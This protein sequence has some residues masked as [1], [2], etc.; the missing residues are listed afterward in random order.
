MKIKKNLSKSIFLLCTIVLFA[1]TTGLSN[2]AYGAESLQATTT[3]TKLIDASS[4]PLEVIA[5]TSVNNLQI[6][7]NDS[8]RKIKID[9]DLQDTFKNQNGISYSLILSDVSGKSKTFIYNDEVYLAVN[10]PVHKTLEES[11]PDYFSGKISV[12]IRVQN[13]SGLTLAVGYLLRSTDVSSVDK[14]LSIINN[15]CYLTVSSTS[16][17]EAN[18]KYNLVQ[19]VDLGLGEGLFLNCKVENKYSKSF[20]LIPEFNTYER[21]ISGNLI[22]NQKL[23]AISI[24]AGSSSV[25]IKVPLIIKSQSYDSVFSLQTVLN[26]DPSSNNVIFHYVIRGDSGTVNIVNTDKTSYLIEETAKIDLIWSPRADYFPNS[27][28]NWQ[29][30]ATSTGL[31]LLGTLSIIDANGEMCADPVNFYPSVEKTET[32]NLQAVI[33]KDCNNGFTTKID[34]EQT[35]EKTGQISKL[36][37]S[38]FD[39][40][41]IDKTVSAENPNSSQN[42]LII[43]NIIFILIVIVLSIFLKL[44]SKSTKLIMFIAFVAFG[45][46]FYVNSAKADTYSTSST[47][48]IVG[49]RH[50]WSADATTNIQIIT[51]SFG[52]AQTISVAETSS[53]LLCSNGLAV[54][55][56]YTIRVYD[57]R[58]YQ[59][60]SYENANN[61]DPFAYGWYD[62]GGYTG[63]VSVVTDTS[64]VPGVTINNHTWYPGMPGNYVAYVNVYGLFDEKNAQIGSLTQWFNLPDTGSVTSDADI[65]LKI[66]QGTTASPSIV[67]IAVEKNNGAVSPLRIE[68]DGIMHG[69]QLVD[70]TD[71]LAS[72]LKIQTSG[73]LKFLKK[74]S[75]GSGPTVNYAGLNYTEQQIFKTPGTFT[76]TVPAGVSSIVVQ[77]WGGGGGGATRATNSS[78]TSGGQ[79]SFGA[80]IYST[81]G[82]GGQYSVQAPCTFNE[83]NNGTMDKT[84]GGAGGVGHGGDLNV[85]GQHGF[86]TSLS[87][88]S[89][90]GVGSIYGLFGSPY[91]ANYGNG[92]WATTDWWY[93][94][95]SAGWVTQYRC[96][97]GGGGGGGYTYSNLSVT[98][99][100]T[101]TVIVGA[102][103]TGSDSY[104]V[105][106]PSAS[107]GAVVISW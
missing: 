38:T 43:L 91:S 87:G 73:G 67:N 24:P 98:P 55:F 60:Y 83:M 66:N 42:I 100:Q 45:S 10:E 9:F 48:R 7:Y 50:G 74:Y 31:K 6:K 39:T 33:K 34:V 17:K 18:T 78:G 94:M 102:A 77:T 61:T 41:K 37:G 23:D 62:H 46:L 5:K 22:A 107:N 51:N 93:H 29:K 11:M 105:T 25:K 30:N 103:G 59:V 2:K 69:I 89:N 90:R 95:W 58:G 26:T 52:Q 82:G 64:S 12:F 44:R 65:G 1:L 28:S 49:S 79:T 8:T 72:K 101:F 54:S 3:A 71:T 53:H 92:G 15:S 80:S 81:G 88:M 13:K 16:T 21:S 99:G 57:Q 40:P 76:F 70:S 97:G 19:G 14:S 96:W 36:V 32:I 84:Y 56:W 85:N 104:D 106:V 20:K 63:N 35:N 4:T 68:K 75:A 27:R 86:S 47:F